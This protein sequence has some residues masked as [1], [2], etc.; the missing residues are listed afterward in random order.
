MLVWRVLQE[1]LGPKHSR[2]IASDERLR[3][4]YVVEWG[5]MS[6]GR[7]E[8]KRTPLDDFV[9]V[10]RKKHL[11]FCR[12]KHNT[13]LPP[14]VVVCNAEHAVGQ[15]GIFFGDGPLAM[16][17]PSSAHFGYNPFRY[18]CENFARQCKTGHCRCKQMEQLVSNNVARLELPRTVAEVLLAL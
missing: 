13:C 3:E 8:I 16:A 10:A 5:T 15:H 4:G 6:S 12:V 2:R 18:N 14:A 1:K 9:R 17:E 7:F 11:D